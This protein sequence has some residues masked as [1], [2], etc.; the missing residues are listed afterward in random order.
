MGRS[1]RERVEAA[2]AT[3]RGKPLGD[4]PVASDAPADGPARFPEADRAGTY[5]KT[6]RSKG[7]RGLAVKGVT[8]SPLCAS[9]SQRQEPTCR[10]P[11]EGKRSWTTLSTD[12]MS[13]ECKEWRQC[14]RHNQK[15]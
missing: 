12:R 14:Q 8:G 2:S 1:L 6:S 5:P 10:A 11:H 4:G 13:V 9:L 7:R 3:A 15:N